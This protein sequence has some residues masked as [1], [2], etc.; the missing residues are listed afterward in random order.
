MTRA[1]LRKLYNL[2]EIIFEE[3]RIIDITYPNLIKYFRNKKRLG[4]V[5]TFNKGVLYAKG[6]YI[7]ILGADNRLRSDFKKK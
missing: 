3:C 4:I 7:C 6:D 5:K 2:I 1:F